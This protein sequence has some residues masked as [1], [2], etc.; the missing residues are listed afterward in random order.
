MGILIGIAH[1]KIGL[2]TMFVFTN[3]ESMLAW[4]FVIL[5][6]LSTFPAVILAF[7]L[8]K[9]GGTWLVGGSLFSLVAVAILAIQRGESK[10]IMWY[11]LSYSIPMLAL[12]FLAFVNN[13]LDLVKKSH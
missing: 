3:N 13:Y 1:L 10:S 8:P 11:L 5:G 9:V 2:K 4:M 6:P 12:G 7:F